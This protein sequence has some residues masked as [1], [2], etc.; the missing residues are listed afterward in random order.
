MLSLADDRG[1]DSVKSCWKILAPHVVGVTTVD[2][3]S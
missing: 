3:V 2:D 1:T